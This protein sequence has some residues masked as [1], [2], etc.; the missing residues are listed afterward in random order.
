[1][2]WRDALLYIERTVVTCTI[3]LSLTGNG[4][5]SG[6]EDIVDRPSKCSVNCCSA[7]VSVDTFSSSVNTSRPNRLFGVHN[8]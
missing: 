8:K 6:I 1:M 3:S 4:F 5:E 7:Q 2:T